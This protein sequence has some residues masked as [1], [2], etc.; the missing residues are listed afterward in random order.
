MHVTGKVTSA[1]GT[2]IAFERAGDGPALIAVDAA[3]S[4]SG[5][6]PFPAPVELLAPHFIG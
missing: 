2:S 5:F 6:R 3:G 4:Y 1:D